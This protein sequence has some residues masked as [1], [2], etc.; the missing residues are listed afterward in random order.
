MPAAAPGG[1]LRCPGPGRRDVLRLGLAALGGVSLPGLFR[2]R[3]AA[4][5][6]PS[7]ERT[8]LIVVRLRPLA[9]LAAVGVGVAAG[10]ATLVSSPLVAGASAVAVSVLGLLALAD[11]ARSASG[12]AEQAVN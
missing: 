10:V 7:R 2:L 12:L 5:R 8:A 4:A 1:S 9:L 11:A 3:A 6:A